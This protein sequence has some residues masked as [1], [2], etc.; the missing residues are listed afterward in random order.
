[1]LKKDVI[2]ASGETWEALEWGNRCYPDGTF[3]LGEQE[4]RVACDLAV[5]EAERLALK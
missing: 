2:A 5:T 3:E 4:K 1:M